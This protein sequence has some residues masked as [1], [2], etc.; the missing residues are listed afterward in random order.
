MDRTVKCVYENGVLRP[1]TLLL[2]V[3]EGQEYLV[4]VRD[5]GEQLD[6]EERALR[7]A[8][9]LRRLKGEGFIEQEAEDDDELG[10]ESDAEEFEPLQLEGEP[11]SE[12]I[13]KMRGERG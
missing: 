13:I 9:L 6:P 1:V 12:T 7:E 3:A 11:L 10:G 8:E 2:N 4:I 5:W